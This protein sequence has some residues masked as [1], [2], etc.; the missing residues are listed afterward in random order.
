MDLPE[1]MGSC[2]G[3]PIRYDFVMNRH[4]LRP[5][6]TLC[7][8][9][10]ACPLFA[11]QASQAGRLGVRDLDAMGR[12][13]RTRELSDAV[14]RA[15]ANSGGQVLGAERVQFDGRD[16]TRVKVMDGRGRVRYYDEDPQSLF[17]G[18]SGQESA[19]P[20]AANPGRP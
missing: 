12:Q 6:L 10:L 8:L 19:H 1:G 13:E 16:I 20:R 11:Q 15:Q 4:I 3:L 2:R 9:A 14:R 7:A 5:L 17:E 18:R